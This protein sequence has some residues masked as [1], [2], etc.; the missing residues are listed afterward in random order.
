MRA[1]RA[2]EL[3]EAGRVDEARVEL[4]T[5]VRSQPG[6]VPALRQLARFLERHGTAEEAAAM[7]ARADRATGEDRPRRRLRPLPPSKW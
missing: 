5:L 1:R 2:T 4:E 3:E 7:H 6:S